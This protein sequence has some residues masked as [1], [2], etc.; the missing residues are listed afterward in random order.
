M[1]IIGIIFLIAIIWFL[2]A[3]CKWATSGGTHAGPGYVG[4]R[5]ARR[6][7]RYIRKGK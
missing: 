2:N 4:Y 3:V 5:M 1:E 7:G 6:T